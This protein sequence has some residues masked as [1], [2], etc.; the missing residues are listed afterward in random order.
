M[1]HYPAA[2]SRSNFLLQN[3]FSKYRIK[4]NIMSCEKPLI[5]PP[6]HD[7]YPRYNY[8]V[9]VPYADGRD[10]DSYKES[11]KFMSSKQAR[12]EAFMLCAMSAKVNQ[13]LIYLKT[14]SCNGTANMNR[15]YSVYDDPSTTR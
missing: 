6:P 9:N 14:K 12:R 3:F 8:S 13:A 2:R 5:R 10:R 15:T 4:K 7:V 11:K 1:L